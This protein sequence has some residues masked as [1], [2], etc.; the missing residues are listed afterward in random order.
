MH[1]QRQAARQDT[2]SQTH[3]RQTHRHMQRPTEKHALTKRDNAVVLGSE[4]VIGTSIEVSMSPH[5]SYQSRC[6]SLRPFVASPR[7]IKLT[8]V[9]RR[10]Q[11]NAH[12]D[13]VRPTNTGTEAETSFSVLFGRC[14]N[15]CRRHGN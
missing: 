13:T 9:D 8:H 15:G 5:P 1:K 6:H 14:K 11:A 4:T 10:T 2:K 3:A 7:P 12:I